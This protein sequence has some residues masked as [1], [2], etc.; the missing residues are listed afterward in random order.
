LVGIPP[1]ELT[2]FYRFS[3]VLRSIDPVRP[4][5]WTR[6]AHETGF[7]DQS[8]FNKDFVA[9]TGQSPTDFLRLQRRVYTENPEHIQMYRTL[10][11]D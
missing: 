8:H 9:F 10:P 7:Y 6:L 3:H 1:K 4:V 2:R 11:T 5:D